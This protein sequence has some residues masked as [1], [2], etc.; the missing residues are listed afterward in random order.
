M[1]TDILTMLKSRNT[2]ST[3]QIA[4][5]LSTTTACVLAS[6]DHLEFLQY[7]RK[8]SKCTTESTSCGKCSDCTKPDKNPNIV[9]WE[10]CAKY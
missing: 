2:Y 8:V 7:I 6:L 1:L 5:R 10:F 3:E 4:C 9:V